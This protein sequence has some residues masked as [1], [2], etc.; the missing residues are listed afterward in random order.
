MRVMR[1]FQQGTKVTMFLLLALSAATIMTI[2]SPRPTMA[3][4]PLLGTVR[5][6]LRSL[7]TGECQKYEQPATVTPAPS[8][9]PAASSGS[10]SQ[11]AA[12]PQ[13]QTSQPTSTNKA[14]SGAAKPSTS[15]EV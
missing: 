14:S 5:C 7:L 1:G 3:E 13:A 4:G 11:P 15:A 2:S 10:T 9:S 8:S 6:L 12:Q